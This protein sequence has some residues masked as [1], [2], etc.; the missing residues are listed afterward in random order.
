MWEIQQDHTLL[1]DER[2]QAPSLEEKCSMVRVENRSHSL[3]W[4]TVIIYKLLQTL[5][6][7]NPYVIQLHN[8]EGI[9]YFQEKLW[10]TFTRRVPAGVSW[11][12]NVLSGVSRQNILD[13][14]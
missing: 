2:G 1:Y 13:Y 12:F 9:L 7:S 10:G 4:R 3:P 6:I 8:D 11:W 5:L 14:T